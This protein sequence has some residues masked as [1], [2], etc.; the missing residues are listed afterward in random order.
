LTALPHAAAHSSQSGC[1]GRLPNRI[2]LRAAADAVSKY[3]LFLKRFATAG[4]YLTF[5]LK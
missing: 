1:G 2:D 4:K 5:Q 3:E